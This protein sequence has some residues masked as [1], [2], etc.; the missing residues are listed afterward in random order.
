[1]STYETKPISDRVIFDT[2]ELT[3]IAAV[4]HGLVDPTEQNEAFAFIPEHLTF[5]EIDTIARQQF[6]IAQSVHLFD[7]RLPE[8]S[9]SGSDM[10]RRSLAWLGTFSLNRGDM[11]TA[12]YTHIILSTQ[13]GLK[14]KLASMKLQRQILDAKAQLAPRPAV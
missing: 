1:M 12:E 11:R 4:S 7:P 13:N 6:N 8:S 9:D 2:P 10:M 5:D 14:N 3:A